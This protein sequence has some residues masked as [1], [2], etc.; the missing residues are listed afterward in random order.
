MDGSA[1]KGEQCAAQGVGVEPPLSLFLPLALPP[2]VFGDV[3]VIPGAMESTNIDLGGPV[4]QISPNLFHFCALLTDGRVRCWG[5]ELHGVL[6]YASTM[7]RTPA[8]S[9]DVFLGL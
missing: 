8:Q 2:G 4:A 6:G 3:P 5:T 1:N 9:G 7:S